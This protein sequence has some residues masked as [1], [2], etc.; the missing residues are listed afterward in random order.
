MKAQQK[1]LR[2]YL[3]R[4]KFIYLLMLPGL[5]WY[6]IFRYLPM[7][8]IIIAFKDYKPFWGI[9]GIFTSQWVGLKYFIKFFNSAYCLRLI[10]NTLILSIYSLVWTFPLSITLA[11]FINELHNRHFKKIVQT[12]SYLPHFLSAVIV[13]GMIRNLTSVDGGLLNTIIH[14]FGGESIHFLGAAEW[15]RTIYTVSE[16]WQTIGWSSIVFIA[17]MTGIDKELYEAAMVD[18]AGVFRRM[19]SITLP[20]IFPVIAIMLILRVGSILNLG[21]EK[22]LLLYSPQIYSTADIINTYVYRE[23]VINQNYSFASAVNLFTA[24]IS[25]IL[26]LGTNKITK[27]MGQGG[28][29]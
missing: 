2:F 24:V 11:L 4:D 8:G 20:G 21:Y 25:L 10:S 13:C 23:G 18:G 17:A 22:I 9:E 6:L 3:K 27:K 29:W 28:I 15:F 7:F 5:L 14:A 1:T 19:W 12:V 16:V 26:V